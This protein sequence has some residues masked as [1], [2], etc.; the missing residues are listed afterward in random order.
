MMFPTR[1]WNN[2]NNLRLTATDF[3]SLDQTYERWL[4]VKQDPQCWFPV[5]WDMIGIWPS[6]ASPGGV[7]RIDYLA[8][9]RSLL[10]DDDN[11]ELPESTQEAVILYGRYMGLLKQWDAD[12]AKAIFKDLAG[13]E[14]FGK[15]R[16]G[17]LRVKHRSF[18]RNPGL[19]LP[20]MPR[21]GS[22]F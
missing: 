8:W 17:I 13:E 2:Q 21:E 1:I 22:S 20:S 16:S 3:H 4:H 6:P 19:S 12:R 7:L 14:A 15:A 10:D 5:G 18:S 9:P 11:P